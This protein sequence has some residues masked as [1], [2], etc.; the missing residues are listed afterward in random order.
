[1]T[2]YLVKQNRTAYQIREVEVE[3]DDAEL[4]AEYD[5]D[6]AVRDALSEADE[7]WKTV[8]AYE[9]IESQEP[10][11]ANSAGVAG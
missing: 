11:E 8:N 4:T 6:Q 1:M 7:P 3:I 9:D 10:I 2:K 5:L